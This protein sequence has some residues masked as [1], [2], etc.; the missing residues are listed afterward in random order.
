VGSLLKNIDVAKS[1]K[2]LCTQNDLTID[3]IAWTSKKFQTK[4]ILHTKNTYKR[5]SQSSII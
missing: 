2:K 5:N 3:M 1:K 4:N